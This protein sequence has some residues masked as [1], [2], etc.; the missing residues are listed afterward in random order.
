MFHK[1]AKVSRF[2]R[3]RFRD[4]SAIPLYWH[5]GQPNFGDDINPQ[6]FERISGQRMRLET[7]QQKPHLLGMGSILNRST[8]NS[9]ILG[10]GM[11]SPLACTKYA[12][13]FAVRGQKSRDTLGLSSNTPLGDPMVTIGLFIERNPK[14]EL[15]IVPHVTE[16][17][18]IRSAMG[19]QAKIIDPAAS[20]M[21]VVKAISECKLILSQSLHGL[22]VA[23][24]LGIP[25][26]WIEPSSKMIGG[27]FKFHDYFSTIDCPKEAVSVG[28]L[29][30]ALN[31]K[32]FATIGRFHYNIKQYRDYLSD[33]VGRFRTSYS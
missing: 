2:L 10:S 31:L 32:G 7:G 19:K 17:A 25:N 8:A 9:F 26:V 23:D 28:D 33:S 4:H 24:A 21:S 3:W 15:G 27:E 18:S 5:I 16:F 12:E 30:R 1:V 11:L 22:I 6:L 29:P 13:V 14:Y 20:P